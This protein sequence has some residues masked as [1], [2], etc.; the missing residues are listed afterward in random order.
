MAHHSVQTMHTHEY[1]LITRVDAL[2]LYVECRDHRRTSLGEL[3]NDLLEQSHR[4]GFASVP[5][6]TMPARYVPNQVG[7]EHLANCVDVPLAEGLVRPRKRSTF[8]CQ[9]L[10][11]LLI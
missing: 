3:R 4:V 6:E 9:S 2:N 10:L 1:P 7:G 5:G 8:G 11:P